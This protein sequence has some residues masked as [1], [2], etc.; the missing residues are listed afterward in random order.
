MDLYNE[1]PLY[2]E[3]EVKLF[4]LSLLKWR[5]ISDITPDREELLDKMERR[6]H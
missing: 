6:Q 2:I 3:Y 5:F 4:L 1:L